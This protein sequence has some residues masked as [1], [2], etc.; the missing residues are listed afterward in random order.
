I[1]VP[2]VT[3][4]AGVSQG[5]FYHYFDDLD[6]A[7]I[8]LVEDRIVPRLAEAGSCVEVDVDAGEDLERSLTQWYESLAKLLLNEPHLVRATLLAAPTGT[9]RAS[10][11]CRETIDGLRL[12]GKDLL[13][14]VNG[15]GPYRLVDTSLVSQMVVGMIVQCAL[16]GLG[17]TDPH[18]WA[19]QMARFEVWGLVRRQNEPQE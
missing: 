9:G 16:T 12:W 5:L 8:A 6:D 18:Y 1:S 10:D 7:F 4:R 19:Q 13:D 2:V 17:D 3:R 11:Y 15:T 14:E